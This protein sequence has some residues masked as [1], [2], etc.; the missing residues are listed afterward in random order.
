MVSI[1][2]KAIPVKKVLDSV[3]DRSAGGVVTFVGTVRNQSDGMRVTQMLLEAAEDLASKD[4]TRICKEA[5]AK[6]NVLRIAVTHRVGKLSVGDVIVAIAV[7]APH[8]KDAFAACQHVIDELK[9]T[10]PI[11]KKESGPGKQKWV[12]GEA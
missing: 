6:H 2:Q 12:K 5:K 11:W 9:K 1:T 4:L 8:R 3:K 10:T 7:S